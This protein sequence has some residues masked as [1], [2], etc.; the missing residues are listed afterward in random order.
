ML[1]SFRAKNFRGFTDLAIGSSSHPLSRVNLIAGKN[2]VGKTALIEAV[3]LHI[4]PDN[5]LLPLS[6]NAIRGMERFSLDPGEMWGWL[7]RNADVHKPIE[8]TSIDEK[9]TPRR[10]EICVVESN[11]ISTVVKPQ[12]SNGSPSSTA[13]ASSPSGVLPVSQSGASSA[14]QASS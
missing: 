5:P 4:G 9:G 13:I 8:L 14:V 12:G 1:Q 10:L 7:F 3:F 6:V 2:D 11:L